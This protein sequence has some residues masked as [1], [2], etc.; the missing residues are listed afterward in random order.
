MNNKKL[1]LDVDGVILN[2]GEKYLELAREILPYPVTPNMKMYDLKDFLQISQEEEAKV[3]E[4]F[5]HRDYWTSIN[6]LEGAIEA[7]KS[8]NELNLDVYIVSS[9]SSQHTQSRLK[10]LAKIGLI[11]KEIYCVG[12][13][14]AHKNE[15]IS[16]IKPF[17]FV[18]D[19]LDHLYRSLD[20]PHLAW[21]DQNHIQVMEPF[22]ELHTKNTSLKQWVDNYLP[23]LIQKNKNGHTI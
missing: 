12:D 20:V 6:P 2:F 13:G 1:V 21:I 3:W 8:I 4:E 23:N 7:I 10:N 5:C 11:P 17:A 19:R 15:I 14:H 16:M 18:D 22:P 9:I